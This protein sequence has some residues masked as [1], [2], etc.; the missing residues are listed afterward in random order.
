MGNKALSRI[1]RAI[2]KLLLVCKNSGFRGGVRLTFK[3]LKEAY[4][5]HGIK[6]IVSKFKQTSEKIDIVDDYSYVVNRD[7]IALNE[8]Q[9]EK[10]MSRDGIIINWIVPDFGTGASGGHTTIF[11]FISS[12][13]KKGIHNKV[14]LWGKNVKQSD[15]D[16]LRH[17]VKDN[18]GI[19]NNDYE[20]D[21]DISNMEFAHYTVATSWQTAYYL[22]TYNN[23][24]GKC[25]FI[26][27]YEPFFYPMGSNYLLAE[28]TYKFG[29]K[30]IFAGD[31]LS[32][33]LSKKYGM[34]GVT[35]SFAYDAA[36]YK[37]N[38]QLKK[39]KS[40]L[41]YARPST[42]RRCFELALLALNDLAG[43]M[44]ELNISFFGE[45]I[46]QYRIPFKHQEYGF[47][48]HKELAKVYGEST[49]CLVMSP[50]NLSL[51]P[52]EAIASGGMIATGL[53]ANN[54]WLLSSLNAVFLS[55][56]PQDMSD[57]LYEV[58]S[59]KNIESKYVA[60]NECIKAHCSW[61]NECSKVADYLKKE[62]EDL[63]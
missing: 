25:Y 44:P 30:G 14:Y 4:M 10:L 5:K 34:N 47:L 49:L 24:L 2:N 39:D 28:N 51:V 41:V 7:V 26:Q 9:K 1:F 59:D 12:F 40:L 20:I 6:G 45:N 60:E 36:I 55:N 33:M 16:Y 52:L 8:N 58:L 46:S 57:K 22:K 19:D 38:Y 48:S 13:E 63:L 17:F 61:D 56:N 62:I 32:G 23:T 31:W 27:D 21:S 29:F 15:S 18:Y 3:L 43:K 53:G 37:Q 50:T 54:E 42:E 11:R 35:F